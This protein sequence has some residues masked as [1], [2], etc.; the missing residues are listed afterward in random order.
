[1]CAMAACVTP[2][3]RRSPPPASR[4]HPRWL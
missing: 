1:M 4:R 3:R 2:S